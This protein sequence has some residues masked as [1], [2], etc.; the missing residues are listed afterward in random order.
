[1]KTAR[2]LLVGLA[3]VCAWAPAAWAE[4]KTTL[5]VFLPT[6]LTDGQER[7]EFAERL[8]EVRQLLYFGFHARDFTFRLT[9]AR[10]RS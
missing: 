6:T 9:M 5:G 4:K 3:L 10:A 1:M 8:F 7:F 2:L